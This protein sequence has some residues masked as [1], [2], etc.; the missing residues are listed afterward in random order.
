LHDD[1]EILGALQQFNVADVRFDV[2][3]SCDI[4]IPNI[5]LD[6]LVAISFTSGSTSESIPQLK[7]WRTVVESSV[8]NQDYYMPPYSSSDP[9]DEEASVTF[10]LLATVPPQHMWGL[11]TSVFFPMFSNVCILAAQPLF[12]KDIL[13]LLMWMPSPRVLVSTPVHLRAMLLSGLS[14]PSIDSILC[15]TAPLEFQAAKQVEGLLGGRLRE[16]Y[17]CSETGS[18]AYRDTV[19][20]SLWRPFHGIDFRSL[21]QC[22]VDVSASHLPTESVRLQDSIEFEGEAFRLLGR[23]SDLI[24]VAGKRGS[25]QEV[26]RL[27]MTADG[28]QDGIVFLPN[29]SLSQSLGVQRLVAMVVIDKNVTSRQ[30]LHDHFKDKLDSALV[31]RPILIVDNLPREDSGKLARQRLNEML[32]SV[33]A[34][35]Q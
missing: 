26:N 22:Q 6:Q 13:E 7:Y 30:K 21:E 29:I 1:L 15:A 9:I 12:P 31:P 5:P 17:G 34:D 24:N 14:Y 18:I 4:P 28:V 11:E 8:I 2:V 3:E 27:L 19:R 16:I 20:Q 32:Q 25:L 35:N 33:L 23:Q 10:Y